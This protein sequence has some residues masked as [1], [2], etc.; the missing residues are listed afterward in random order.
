[1]RARAARPL[2]PRGEAAQGA[3]TWVPYRWRQSRR[4][5]SPRF[6][7]R[8]RLIRARR[9]SESRVTLLPV[10]ALHPGRPCH[11][12]TIATMAPRRSPR[13]VVV[14]ACCCALAERCA[15]VRAG[16]AAGAGSPPC[17]RLRGRGEI[18]GAPA[19]A[20]RA[21]VLKCA[22]RGARRRQ[23]PRR[24]RENPAAREAARA[25]PRR[26]GVRGRMGRCASRARRSARS[27]T[28]SAGS[29]SRRAR[30]SPRAR[31]CSRASTSTRSTG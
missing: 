4:I 3:A 17:G 10:A 22:L 7:L 20:A 6:Q 16:R 11:R 5:A 27:S 8:F 15:R 21:C 26:G 23:V 18:F 31:T 30:S 12:R 13:R 19:V 1:M 9:S 14:H 28:C 24:G 25:V 29:T 2:A